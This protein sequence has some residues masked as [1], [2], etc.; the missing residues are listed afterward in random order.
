MTS[1]FSP[2]HGCC[3]PTARHSLGSEAAAWDAGADF[4]GAETRTCEQHSGD[5]VKREGSRATGARGGEV[6]CRLGPW[7]K[8]LWGD[9]S[10]EVGEGAP[11]RCGRR[12]PGRAARGRHGA[13]CTVRRLW[14]RSPCPRHARPVR[15]AENLQGA[16]LLLPRHVMGAKHP[17]DR[18]WPEVTLVRPP[19]PCTHPQASDC[20]PRGIHSHA[21]VADVAGRA[22]A[23]ALTKL[24]GHTAGQTWGAGGVEPLATPSP[25]YTSGLT[26]PVPAALGGICL[27]GPVH[28]PSGHGPPCPL[29]N[30]PFPVS[31]TSAGLQVE[32]SCPALGRQV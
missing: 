24:Q 9:R 13:P 26:S 10:R 20:G 5:G 4:Q 7:G 21:Q 23:C 12:P 16:R 29:G 27:P 28:F 2:A 11:R 30:D 1:S 17:G 6:N 18:G 14:P 8:P 25:S 31:F 32:V 3:V 19:S 22:R 15:A